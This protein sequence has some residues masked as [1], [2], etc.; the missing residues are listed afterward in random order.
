MKRG[1]SLGSYD[2]G[3]P[4]TTGKG[5]RQRVSLIISPFGVS[6]QGRE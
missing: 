5:D 4:L 2:Y 1:F 3:V 6:S